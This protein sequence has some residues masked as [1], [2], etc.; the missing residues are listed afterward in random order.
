MSLKSSSDSLNFLD[1]SSTTMQDQLENITA[2]ES[3]IG[4]VLVSRGHISY[5]HASHVALFEI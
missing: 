1:S 5:A 3:V 2:A 4:T